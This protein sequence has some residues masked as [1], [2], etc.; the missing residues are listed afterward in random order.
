MAHRITTDPGE[1]NVVY[2]DDRRTIVR[3]DSPLA[4]IIWPI[5][6]IINL[7]LGLRF[8]LRLV[9]SDPSTGFVDLVYRLSSPLADPFLGVVRSTATTNG[10]IEWSTLVA[11]IAYWLAAWILLWATSAPRAL[12]RY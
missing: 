11:M 8:L 9:G 5:L 4:R 10:V 7:L 3:Y 12:T 2:D 1:R 6:T